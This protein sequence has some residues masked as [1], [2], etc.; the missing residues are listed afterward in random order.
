[1]A[2]LGKTLFLLGQSLAVGEVLRIPLN[3]REN[4]QWKEILSARMQ[5][6]LQVGASDD[7]H[8]LPVSDF[9]DS[10]YTA[11]IK[12]GTPGVEET[13]IFDTGSSNLWVP[14]KQPKGVESLKEKH[15]YNHD[16]SSTY[17]ADGTGFHI[18]Y[19]SGPVAGFLSVDDVSFGG[20][21]MKGYKFAEVNEMTG[22]GK[23]Y[24]ESP[25]DGIL[26][27]AFDSIAQDHC[28]SPMR[29]LVESGALTDP[30]F[31]FYLGP[32]GNELVLGGVD[33]A[34]YQ[35]DFQYIPLSAETYWQV[36]L[37]SLKINGK[38]I[39]GLF[40]TQSAFVDS[41]TSFLVGPAA[42]L[43]ALIKEMGAKL[44][45][46]HGMFALECDKVESAPNVTFTLGGGWEE[47]GTDFTLEAKDLLV[48][49]L[50]FGSTCGL[51]IQPGGDQW[52][53]GDVFMRKY[54]VQFDYGQKRLGIAPSTAGLA[55]SSDTI[56]V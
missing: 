17:K 47:E 1:M 55:R 28:P 44:D 45:Q 46:E 54:Y 20:L 10:L 8:T 16:S 52:I 7:G 21:T 18:Q 22:L 49:S 9:K 38:K 53:L 41:G 30:V 50:K 23:N 19:G 13:V 26:G 32:N 35:G 2:P 39:G 14:N 29:T 4:P 11:K 5:H 48:D 43:Q 25:M 40:A 36:H 31:A 27:M 24:L 42:D 37:N 6:G 15:V 3:K 34:H 12:V 56:V 33:K 51:A